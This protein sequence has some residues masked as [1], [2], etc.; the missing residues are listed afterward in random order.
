MSS[1][2]NINFT[3]LYKD[4]SS[5]TSQA[6]INR[7]RLKDPSLREFLQKE[8]EP[9]FGAGSDFLASPVFEATFGWKPAAKNCDLTELMSKGILAKNLVNNLSKPPLPLPENSEQKA[10]YIANNINSSSLGPAARISTTE[11]P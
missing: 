9:K 3:A 4:L 7:M 8:F 11:S 2:K 10:K 6:V 1:N 5:V